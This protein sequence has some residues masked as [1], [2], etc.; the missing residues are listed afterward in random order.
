MT[1]QED[2]NIVNYVREIPF[3]TSQRILEAVGV[4]FSAR[5]I[6]RRL[7]EAGIHARVPAKK[8]LLTN[9][10]AAARMRFCQENIDRD[11]TAVIFTDEKVFSSSQDSPAILWRAQNTCYEPQ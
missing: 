6:R 7:H 9:A 1:R 11:W 4:N 3:T 8:P 5:T 2:D 10:H